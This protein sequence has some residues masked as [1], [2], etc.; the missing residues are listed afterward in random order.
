MSDPL[1][2]PICYPRDS[3]LTT[4]QV[5]RALAVS[6]RTV[7]RLD[8]PTVYLGGRLKRFLWGRV[9]DTLDSRAK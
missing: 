2:A 5:A 9:L 8:L 3:I 4:Q 7:E 1:Q 6:V